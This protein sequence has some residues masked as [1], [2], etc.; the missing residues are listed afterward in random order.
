[1][2]ECEND[3]NG[4]CVHDCINIPGNYRCTCYDGFMLADDGHNCLGKTLE[5]ALPHTHILT[6]T[7]SRHLFARPTTSAVTPSANVNKSAPPIFWPLPPSASERPAEPRLAPAFQLV[8]TGPTGTS[9]LF[10]SLKNVTQMSPVAQPRP[11]PGIRPSGQMFMLADKNG[12][13]ERKG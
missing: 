10:S 2:D 6:R 11:I 13:W 5:K 12:S 9:R 3:Y 1:M 8:L 4:G 7:F